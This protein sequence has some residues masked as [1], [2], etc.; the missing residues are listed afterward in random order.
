MS[1]DNLRSRQVILLY[2][3]IAR[4]ESDPWSL[5]VTPEHFAEHLDALRHFRLVELGHVK[6]STN[7]RGITSA[8]ITFDDGYADNFYLAGPLL[9]RYE[10]PATF[11]V[12]AGYVGGSR[13]FWWDELEKIVFQSPTL[14]G[15]SA[16]LEHFH[17]QPEHSRSRLYFCLYKYLQPMA[18]EKR[19]HLLDLL[20]RWTNLSSTARD[21]HRVMTCNE[22][23]ALA[24]A[25]L[26]EIGAHTVTHP[27]LASQPLAVQ[28]TEI[29]EG[30]RL[31]EELVN[32][33]ITSFSYPYGGENHYSASTVQLVRE[34]GFNR[35]CSAM[36]RPV[37]GRDTPYQLPRFNITNMNGEALLRLLFS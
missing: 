20:L 19:R 6:P 9:E 37:D 34:A 2:H 15:I 21:S 12:A 10:I 25:N 5:C 35:A 26:I 30:K 3:R 13:E 31:L 11:F 27:Q 28:E 22:L 23:S 7:G 18:H 14:S 24:R 16:F 1:N 32:R 36:A 8:I 17:I 29:R 4:I 33:P